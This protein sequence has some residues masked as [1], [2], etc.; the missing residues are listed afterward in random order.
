MGTNRRLVDESASFRVSSC[1]KLVYAT[2]NGVA[3]DV[4]PLPILAPLVGAY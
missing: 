3:T 4:L 1:A 2:E